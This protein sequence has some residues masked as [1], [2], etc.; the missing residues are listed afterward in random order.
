MNAKMPQLKPA[1]EAAGFTDV[2]T[3]LSSGNV[4]FTANKSARSTLESKAEAAM[5]KLLGCDFLTIVRPIDALR[6]MLEADPYEQFRVSQKAKRVVTFLRLQKGMTR[7]VITALQRAAALSGIRES[8][9]LAYAYAV[10]GQR[11][12]ASTILRSLL[13]Q[14]RRRYLSPFHIAMAYAGLRDADAAFGCWSAATRSAAR[15]WTA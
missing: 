1:F 9:Q 6:K 2:K 14:E 4:V 13:E 3:V 12:E 7:E 8:A 15:S 11:A 10:T 5:K